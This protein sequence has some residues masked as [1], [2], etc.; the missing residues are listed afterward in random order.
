MELL[1]STRRLGA[2]IALAVL[3]LTISAG[4]PVEGRGTPASNASP[5]PPYRTPSYAAPTDTASRK[6]PKLEGQLDLLH[7]VDALARTT[8]GA[9]DASRADDLPPSLRAAV[10]A[11]RLQIDQDGLVHVHALAS[12]DAASAASELHELGMVLERVSAEHAIVQ[13][14]LPIHALAAAASL[15]SIRFIRP[16]VYGF[17][18]TGSVTTQ[19]DAILDANDLRTTYGLNGASVRVGVL[20]IGLEG[21][22]AAQA[23]GDLPGS[24]NTSCDFAPGLPTDPGMGAEGTAMLEIV[25]DV[26]PGAE[27][28][29]GS[30]ETALDF[31][32][33]V[34]CLADNVDV[35]IDDILFFNAGSYDGTSP[36]SLNLTAEMNDA[37]NRVRAY[38][39]AVGNDALQHYQQS[40]VDIDPGSSSNQLHAFSATSTTTDQLGVGTNASDPIYLLSGG[41][42]WIELQW[43]DTF[44]AS[45]NDYDL[46][47]FRNSDFALVALSEG[48]QSGT[49]DPVETIVFQNTGPDRFYDIVINKWSGS[50]RTFDMFVPWCDCVPLP[51]GLSNE[52]VL[53][54]NT[55]SSSVP[56]NPDATG[57]VVSH[58]AINAAEP[59]NDLIAPYSSRGPTN[60]GLTKP[61]AVAI[62]GVAVSGAG[63]FPSTFYGTST[64]AAHG[65]AIA[66]LILACAPSLK[67]GEP[68]DNPVGDRTALRNAILNS[69]LDLGTAGNDNTYGRGR[70][71]A[72]AAAAAASCSTD[73]DADGVGNALDNCPY[74]ANTPQTNTDLANASIFPGAD[75][76]GDACDAD[77]DGDGC[78][79]TEEL[80]ANI[81]T[82]GMR[83][84][85]NP[86]DLADV[87]VPALPTLP[88]TKN[89]A[90]S[91]FDVSATLAWVG[92]TTTNG[93]DAGGHNYT[94]DTNANGVQDGTEYDRTPAGDPLGTLSGPPNGAIS[95]H[96]VGVVLAQVG[97][98]CAAPPN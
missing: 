15:P 85:V 36:V 14:R 79:D 90:I 69:A 30:F 39:N 9:I 41:L 94:H 88:S 58:G 84:P 80:G 13:G 1:G 60:G 40:Y 17:A 75:P 4:S 16:P 6:V 70:L 45:S 49:Q 31:I 81:L 44:G 98:S 91:L 97:H 46:Y 18:Q 93:T 78:N 8:G 86:W 67:H 57:L 77:D 56:N 37:S 43:N 19:G 27:L 76:L 12:A 10:A 38:H 34:D 28:W 33:A 54:Y 2:V 87:P 29:F 62:D 71:D 61:E 22:A 95:L 52:P 68:G 59:G 23:S 73:V 21:M 55:L 63:G 42:V 48:V 83:D 66:A 92:R 96:D 25:H 26:A 89:K 3:A 72:D 65:G 53:N 51:N 5:L 24:I 82:G 11:R 64:A 47:L 7:R 50:T 32:S 74:V 35:I 20:S